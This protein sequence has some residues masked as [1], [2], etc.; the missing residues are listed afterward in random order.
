MPNDFG[1]QQYGCENLNIHTVLQFQIETYVPELFTVLQF[2]TETY[3]P[4]LFT[5]L[6]FHTEDPPFLK[7]QVS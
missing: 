7:P 3:V 2:Q 5:V 4:E 6:Q 1:L